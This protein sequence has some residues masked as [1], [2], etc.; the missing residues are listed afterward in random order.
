MPALTASL[1]G[2]EEQNQAAINALAL[3]NNAVDESARIAG[4]SIKALEEARQ[5]ELA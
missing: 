5:R 3:F 4:E 2:L 1:K